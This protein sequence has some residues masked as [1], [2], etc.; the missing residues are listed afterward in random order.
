MK[1]KIKRLAPKSSKGA[2]ARIGIQ[3][4]PQ[5]LKEIEAVLRAKVTQTLGSLALL[6]DRAQIR[7][8]PS[9]TRKM[10]TRANTLFQHPGDAR[11]IAD[12]WAAEVG[13]FATLD[14]QHFLGNMVLRQFLPFPL[15][16]PGDALAWA[17]DQLLPD[18]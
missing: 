3:V 12:A 13:F 9:A 7:I 5:V 14:K 4:S 17:R 10:L 18:E 11:V 6:L 1:E 15:G 16:T 2:V 8:A